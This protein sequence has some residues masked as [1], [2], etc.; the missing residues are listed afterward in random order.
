MQGPFRPESGLFTSPHGSNVAE[1]ARGQV[2]VQGRICVLDEPRD[3][4]SQV[5]FGGVPEF[6]DEGMPLERLLND[7]SLDALAAAVNQPDLTKTS[8]VRGVDVLLDDRRDVARR[9]RVQVEVVFDRDAVGHHAPFF[10]RLKAEATAKDT[11][12]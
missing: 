4:R 12:R 8:F 1:S 2:V 11:S 7:A 5:S 9:E 3:G 6:G 10:F